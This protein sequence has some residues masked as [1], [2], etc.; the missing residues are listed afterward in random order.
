MGAIFKRELRSYF[1]SPIAYVFAGTFMLIAGIFFS[2]TNILNLNSNFSETLGSLT[3]VFMITIPV[4]TMRLFSQEKK[5][6]T[7]QLLLTSGVSV[8]G[9]VLGKYFAASVVYFVTL[10]ISLIFP[11]I[12]SYFGVVLFGEMVSAYTGFLLLGLVMTAIGMFVSTLTESQVI[13]AISTSAIMLMLWIGDSAL[14]LVTN[15]SAK[16]VLD[17]FSLFNRL[18]PF[19]LGRLPLE[20]I[21]YYISFAVIFVCTSY[22]SV[23]KRR[24]S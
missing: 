2:I 22:F 21:I 15:A 19:V 7:D 13:A 20:N 12:I 11:L 18:E 9:I 1:L 4:L 10:I 23:E 5:E 16:N 17:W 24:W 3:F 14:D 6:K 8:Y